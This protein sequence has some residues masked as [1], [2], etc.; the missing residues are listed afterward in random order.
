MSAERG[1]DC[2][3][4]K[5]RSAPTIQPRLGEKKQPPDQLNN[6]PRFGGKK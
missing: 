6:Q 5:L 2:M 3:G 1:S 4:R